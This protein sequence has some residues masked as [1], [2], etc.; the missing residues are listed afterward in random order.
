[1]NANS[2][3]LELE[4]I[5]QQLAALSRRARPGQEEPGLAEVLERLAAALESLQQLA[6]NL[7][8]ENEELFETRQ[9]V[10]VERERYLTLFEFA[11]DG[12]LVTNLAG[13]IQ[14]ANRAATALFQASREFLVGKPLVVFVA[15]E[16]HPVFLTRLAQLP[17]ERGVHGWE[18]S[19]WLRTGK[20]IH[21]A[22]NV[23][24]LRAAGST[25]ASLHWM[26]RDISEQKRL[27]ARF[28]ATVEAAP[29]AMVMIDS[30]G[31]IVL[32]NAETVRLF[33]YTRQELLGRGV[34]VL[35]P[36]RFR[37]EHPRLRSQFFA[38]PKARRMGA[39]RD[40]FGLRKDGSEFP[41]EIGL[42]PIETEEGLFVL[43]AIVDITERKR[44]EEALRR[45]QQWDEALKTI[46]QAATSL[47][48][49][50]EILTSGAEA[51]RRASGATL[52]MVRLVDPKTRDLVV[53]A[54][55]GVPAEYLAVGKRI[56]WGR[57]LAGTVAA[58]GQPR[59]VGRPEEQPGISELSLLASRAQSLACLPLQAGS[60]VL[61]TLTLGHH[62][63]IYFS[64]TDLE[65]CRPAAS[66]LAGA[67][68]AE[69]LRVAT[70]KEAE[71]KALLFREMDHRV[72]NHLAALISLLHLGA[73]GS[74]GTAAERLREM[75]E[76]VAR[77]AEVHNLLSGRGI[78]PIEVRELAEGI[79]KNVLV[80]LPGNL[81]IQWTVTGDPVR[82]P[83][84][85][86]TAIAL[87]LNELLTNCTKHAFPG[88]ATGTVAIRVAHEDNQIDLEVQ[89]D[90]VGL[91]LAK[92]AADLGMT[93][94]QTIVTQTLRGTVA[95]AAEGGTRV[96]VR[97][98]HIEET[99]E[100]GSA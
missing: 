20:R 85:Q 36:E 73:E 28:R 6:E 29:T 94:V 57:E 92:H 1:M 44:N 61:G 71:E 97:F 58:S 99:P 3:E 78:Q 4:A 13:V 79:A 87:I 45:Q 10:E 59:A 69:R 46:G 43:S 51:I 21:A 33:A 98:P 27:E 76:R 67:I 34:E 81:K 14:E 83:P 54:H 7:R 89:D 60:R 49:L 74:E 42:N 100:G 77:V 65:V 23:A 90:G 25:P 48:P 62:Q 84:S 72:R 39:G 47:L 32:V 64:P 41:V 2:V 93:I 19:L 55:R 24:V 63:A 88:R 53:A 30:A 95:F 35:V 70:M 9:A 96:T 18:V 82:I 5:R 31:S 68:L 40:L 50:E 8:V 38:S 75:A 17:T 22:V 80:A 91:D 86:V 56:P 66:M 15:A 26:I 16:E 37:G 52:A 11:P 12:Y